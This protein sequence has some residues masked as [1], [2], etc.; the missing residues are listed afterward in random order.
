MLTPTAQRMLATLPDYY[1]GE[2]LIERVVQARANEID[3]IDALIDRVQV[4]LQPANATDGLGLLALWE[5]TLSLPARPAAATEAQR[6]A[7]VQAVLRSVGGSSS[8]ET[9]TAL[10]A[11]MAGSFTVSR[12][13]PTPLSDTLTIPYD[14][15]TY[16]AAIVQIIAAR[17]W[18]AHRRLLLHFSNGFI[19]DVSLL[20]QDTL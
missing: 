14:P 15:G 8:A 6:R 11:A 18:P 16:N 13:T 12:D 4:E 5:K 9:L 2:P 20:D 7:K 1:Q 10:A 17:L 3:R 19:L